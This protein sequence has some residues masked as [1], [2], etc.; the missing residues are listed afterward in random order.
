[1][2]LLSITV[3]GTALVTAG[4]AAPAASEAM[5]ARTVSKDG[6]GRF[7][8]TPGT[9]HPGDRVELTVRGCPV[10]SKRPWASSAAFVDEVPLTAG[11]GVAMVAE[12]ADSG[13][14]EVVAHCGAH[15]LLGTLEVSAVRSWPSILPDALASRSG[16]ARHIR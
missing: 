12:A 16:G 6:H 13:G 14:Y 5:A 4:L 3:L 10:G 15:R 8:F 11:H 7:A 9:V 1:M 2:R